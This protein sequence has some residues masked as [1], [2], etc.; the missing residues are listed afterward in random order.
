MYKVSSGTLSSVLRDSQTFASRKADF[1]DVTGH[2]VLRYGQNLHTSQ[3][4]QTT[5]NTNSTRVT[6]AIL[7]WAQ[8]V[9]GLTPGIMQ[10]A[11]DRPWLGVIWHLNQIVRATCSGSKNWFLT[12]SES[13]CIL[14]AFMLTMPNSDL[15][16]TFQHRAC[17]LND[18]VPSWHSL[19]GKCLHFLCSVLT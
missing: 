11:L 8:P 13:F 14:A 6:R 4:V 10:L 9:T 12:I 2:S 5:Y 19:T 18:H 1:R 17:H 7:L 15:I 3:R 16:K